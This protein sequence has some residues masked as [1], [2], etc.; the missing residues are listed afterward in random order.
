MGITVKH[1]EKRTIHK[2]GKYMRYIYLNRALN[3]NDMRE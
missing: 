3:M 2:I 1:V